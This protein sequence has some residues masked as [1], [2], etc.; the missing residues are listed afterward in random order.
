MISHTT[1][2]SSL[3]TN[4]MW[5][6]P[7]Q[8]FSML[9][10]FRRTIIFYLCHFGLSL[11]LYSFRYRP[12]LT[13]HLIH[14]SLHVLAVFSGFFESMH[15]VFPLWILHTWI[16]LHFDFTAHIGKYKKA[17]IILTCLFRY[18]HLDACL[19]YGECISTKPSSTFSQK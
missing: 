17:M 13:S 19:V 4:N 9:S 10:P 18:A 11:S 6:I 15:Q 3:K 14:S 1:S 7:F 2:R 12:S 5:N 16:P 8:P